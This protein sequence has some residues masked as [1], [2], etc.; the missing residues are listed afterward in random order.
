EDIG[1]LKTITET[2]I[3]RVKSTGSL[4][5]STVLSALV[6]GFATGAQI[7]AVIL[8]I[9]TFKQAFED[10]N[11]AAKNLSRCVEAAGAVG[12]NMVPWSVPAFFA[13]G[14]LG[15]SPYDYIPYA[16]FIFLVP[17]INVIYGYTGLSIT[18][19]DDTKEGVKHAG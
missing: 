10:R 16:F 1:V 8:P 14:V 13:A 9:R 11:L 5:G 2:F 6:V 4:I 19:K 7:L 3:N 15:V 12:I 18:K 17:L